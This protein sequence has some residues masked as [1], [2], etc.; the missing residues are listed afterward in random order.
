M[1]GEKHD[2]HH[3]F[4][5]HHDRIHDLKV[6]NSHFARLFDLYHHIDQEVRS[7]ETNGGATTDEHLEDRK[8]ARLKLKDELYAMMVAT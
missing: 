7:I 1:L 6:N 8:L 5:E 3:E 4:P 2:L